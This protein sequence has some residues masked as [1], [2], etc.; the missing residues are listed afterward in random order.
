[1]HWRLSSSGGHAAPPAASADGGDAFP[2]ETCAAAA[3][4]ARF[5][6]DC[7]G[8]CGDGCAGVWDAYTECT[9][10]FESRDA[11]GASC[12]LRCADAAPLSDGAARRS[13]GLLAAIVVVVVG[14]MV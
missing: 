13:A 4:S 12:G 9:W 14:V 1:M 10:N 8:P 11:L 3:A 6:E 5:A 7:D 2:Y